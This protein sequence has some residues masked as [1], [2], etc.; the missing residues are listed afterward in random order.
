MAGFAGSFLT[1]LTTGASGDSVS[2][3]PTHV[4]DEVAASI[5]KGGLH[6]DLQYA[7]LVV[8]SEIVVELGDYKD[9]ELKVAHRELAAKFAELYWQQAVKIRS[10]TLPTSRISPLAQ[11]VGVVNRLKEAYRQVASERGG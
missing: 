9:A 11:R 1:K 8:L 2:G 5:Q 10:W 4:P 7:L 6:R 3:L